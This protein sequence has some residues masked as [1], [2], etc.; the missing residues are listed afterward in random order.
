MWCDVEPRLI[1]RRTYDALVDAVGDDFTVE[2]VETFLTEAPGMLAEL[3]DAIRD[4]NDAAYRRIAHTLKSNSNTFGAFALG[5]LA[6]AAE[7]G[8]LD[9][10]VD[11]HWAVVDELEASYAAVAVALED[12]AHG[13]G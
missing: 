6:Q 8:G 11:A 7:I 9:G 3:R 10:D 1:D 5:D 13:H 4:Q 12:L 2:L